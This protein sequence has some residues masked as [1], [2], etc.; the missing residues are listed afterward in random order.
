MQ[1]QQS[2]CS[3]CYQAILHRLQVTP[4][5]YCLP[6]TTPVLLYHV[7]TCTIQSPGKKVG[8]CCWCSSTSAVPCWP[9]CCCCCRVWSW[10]CV[11]PLG[12]ASAS[13]YAASTSL[14]LAILGALA[15]ALSSALSAAA[16]GVLP[17]ASAGPGRSLGS[18]ARLILS[19]APACKAQEQCSMHSKGA[20]WTWPV[21]GSAA[22][23]AREYNCLAQP[24]PILG[25]WPGHLCHAAAVYPAS[26]RCSCAVPYCMSWHLLC[27]R[28]SRKAGC[29]CCCCRSCAHLVWVAPLGDQPMLLLPMAAPGAQGSPT[30]GAAP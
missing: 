13:T 9:G 17:R 8:R 29:C 18:R 10:S 21:R 19:V 20:T 26:L 4:V 16:A 3:T 15:A 23:Q 5:R 27:C 28:T 14:L 22:K 30:A 7:P 24:R 25:G 1:P 11:M 6:A 12:C 2:T